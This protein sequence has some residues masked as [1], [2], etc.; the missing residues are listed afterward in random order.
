MSFIKAWRIKESGLGF[1]GVLVLLLNPLLLNPYL[2]ALKQGGFMTADLAAY[3]THIDNILATAVDSSTWTTA[4]KDQALRLALQQYD[5]FPV[6]ESSFTVTAAGHMQDLSGITEIKQTLAVAYPWDGQTSLDAISTPHRYIGTN[7]IWFEQVEPQV[8]DLIRVRYFKTHA[9]KDLDSAAETTV[10]DIDQTPLAT[11]AAGWACFLRARQLS[12]NPAPP[13]AALDQ[14]NTLCGQ[15]LVAAREILRPAQPA[16]V[17]WP[18][19][20]L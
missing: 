19:L 3:R 1:A 2:L 20:G 16:A 8:G 5:R 9:I 14:L 10:P 13:R 7:V 12:E 17:A 18:V 15:Y 4:I 6:Y 11:Y